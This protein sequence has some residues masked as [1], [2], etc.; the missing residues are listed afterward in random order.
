MNLIKTPKIR[1]TPNMDKTILALS[2]NFLIFMRK[3][4]DSPTIT[5]KIEAIISKYL[6]FRKKH[7]KY[8]NG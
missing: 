3:I 6:N 7:A 2:S 5:K 4:N 1:I 8:I